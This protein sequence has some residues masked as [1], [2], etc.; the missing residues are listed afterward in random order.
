MPALR[1]GIQLNCLGLPLKRALYTARE[2]GA[3]AVELDARSA[4]LKPLMQSVTAIRELRKLLSD[5]ELRVS[6]VGFR[7]RRGYDTLEDLEARVAATRQAMRFAHSVG[8][9]FVVNQLGFVPEPSE[10]ESE[11]FRLLTDVLRDLGTFGHH[12]G[13]LLVAETGAESAATLRRLIDAM[14]PGTIGIDLNPGNLIINGQ[15][16]LEMIEALGGEILHVHAS[17]AVR[18]LARR[19]GL[20]V[21]LGRGVADY[22]ALLG[23]LE[24]RDFRGDITIQR[25]QSEDPVY[26]IGQAVQYLRRM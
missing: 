20:E 14:P 6:A 5:L 23:A 3:D 22:P 9:R 15:A 4:D 21:A 10:E 24:E 26:E 18:D 25:L 13:A 17:D 7:T 12:E 11:G 1:I 2:L 19:R 16:P 8:A